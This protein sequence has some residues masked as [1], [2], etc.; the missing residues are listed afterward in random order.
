MANLPR[1]LRLPFVELA[2][3]QQQTLD[4]GWAVLDALEPR[5][6]QALV[7][8]MVVA[9]LEDG[10]VAPPEAELLRAACGLM[11]VPLP[12]LLG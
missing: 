5:A 3:P 7:E 10:E 12:A 6:K 1:E 2:L 4:A 11:H 8:A 9:V